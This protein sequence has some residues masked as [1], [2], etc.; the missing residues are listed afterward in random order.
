MQANKDKLKLEN[1]FDMSLYIITVSEQEGVGWAAVRTS[2]TKLCQ[3]VTFF[4]VKVHYF[5]NIRYLN[6]A[7]LTCMISIGVVTSVL[8]I[9]VAVGLLCYLLFSVFGMCI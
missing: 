2:D 6:E 8:I 3:A 1:F 5:W 4:L 7:I 9:F